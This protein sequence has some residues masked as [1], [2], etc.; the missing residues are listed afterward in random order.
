MY[1]SVVHWYARPGAT[2]NRPPLPAAAARPITSFAELQAQSDLIKNGGV[3]VIPG[4]IEGENLVPAASSPGV[5]A[6]AEIPPPEQNPGLVL[7]NGRHLKLP[8]TTAGQFVEFRLTEQFT[9]K[10]IRLRL[11]TFSDY[12]RVDVAVNG[13]TVATDVDLVSASLDVNDLDLGEFDPEDSA[14]TIRVTSAGSGTGGEFAAAVDAFVLTGPVVPGLQIKTD[15]D[16]SDNSYQNVFNATS[17]GAG[18]AGGG[19]GA[20]TL[21]R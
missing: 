9:E 10:T 7:S 14:L 8:F 18:P 16:F 19:T 12:G 6:V 13:Q 5:T 2:S 3:F 20:L 17:Y 4:A 11:S 1:S 21:V 15:F